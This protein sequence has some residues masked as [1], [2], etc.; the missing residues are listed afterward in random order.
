MGCIQ[1]GVDYGPSLFGTRVFLSAE[2]A[3]GALGFPSPPPTSRSSRQPIMNPLIKRLLDA[4]ES[5]TPG[6]V[7]DFEALV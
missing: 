1:D 2:V 6:I 3:S 7:Q 5:L 4:A